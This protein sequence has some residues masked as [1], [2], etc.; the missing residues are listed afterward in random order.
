MAPGPGLRGGK[1]KT[2]HYGNR[3]F[4]KVWEVKAGRG[5]WPAYFTVFLLRMPQSALWQAVL[6]TA[7]LT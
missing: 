3:V 4:L 7:R 6:P 1:T 5:T 2:D